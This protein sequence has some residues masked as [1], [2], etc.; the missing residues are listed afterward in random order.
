MLLLSTFEN[1]RVPGG[2]GKHYHNLATIYV[3]IFYRYFIFY[4]LCFSWFLATIYAVKN[5]GLAIGIGVGSSFIVLVSFTWGIFVFDEHVHSRVDACFA[6]G[7]MMAGL[8]GMAYY[9]APPSNTSDNH[10]GLE[11]FESDD[12]DAS[13]YQPLENDEPAEEFC[14]D[15]AP[16]TQ[17][18]NGD[19]SDD[20]VVLVD[21]S[22]ADGSLPE[23]HTIFCGMKWQRRTLG[24][25]SA[26]FTGIYG[27]SIMAPMKWAPPDAKGL[28]Y[29]ISFSIGAATVNLSLWVFRY[30]YL[31][32]RHGS[33]GRA[34][35]A[36]P[37]FHLRKMW[38]YGGICG[39]LWSIG[40]F[41]SIISVE[42]LGEG[43]GY[44]VVQASM[45]GMCFDDLRKRHIFCCSILMF[46]FFRDCHA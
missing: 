25:V 23:T 2:V 24:I 27:G 6:V 31:C 3:C 37:S 46:A 36:L 38:F 22:M 43:V 42:F 32:H 7:C 20:E 9:S 26:M 14:D 40:N 4:F 29:L 1:L 11:G 16:T 44:S 17:A 30:T 5:A 34:Y 35:Q 15:E 12:S 28:G 41:F 8:L 13:D 45:L 18:T 19:E 10:R 33:M 21:T 39:L